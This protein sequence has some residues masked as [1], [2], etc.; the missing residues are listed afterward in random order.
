MRDVIL[1]LCTN[2]R[3]HESALLSLRAAGKPGVPRKLHACCAMSNSV[4][5]GCMWPAATRHWRVCGP[6]VI[7]ALRPA[8]VPESAHAIH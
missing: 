2:L 4:R 8:I 6:G 5:A 3:D 7:R 1:D